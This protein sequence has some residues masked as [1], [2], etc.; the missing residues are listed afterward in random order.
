[1]VPTNYRALHLFSARAVVRRAIRIS[2]ALAP[3]F[4][5]LLFFCNGPPGLLPFGRPELL[6]LGTFTK[7]AASAAERLGSADT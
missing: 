1:M 5:Y 7:P 2:G 6:A 4:C 3:P